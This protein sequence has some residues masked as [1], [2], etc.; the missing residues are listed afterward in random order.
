MSLRNAVVSN[1]E[2]LDV[3]QNLLGHAITTSRSDTATPLHHKRVRALKALAGELNARIRSS[4]E[5]GLRELEQQVARVHDSNKDQ[6][7]M[8]ALAFK[9]VQHWPLIR[10]AIEAFDRE[11]AE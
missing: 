9:V 4:R 11:H 5:R 3:V 7:Q 1:E 6:G 8:I 10:Q 2:K